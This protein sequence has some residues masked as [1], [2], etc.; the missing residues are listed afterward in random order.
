MRP[1]Y[2]ASLGDRRERRLRRFFSRSGGC[3]GGAPSKRSA[4]ARRPTTPA[5]TCSFRSANPGESTS[6]ARSPNSA[7]ARCAP[8]G[9]SPS[10]CRS[11]RAA[12][13]S[14]CSTTSPWTSSAS[15]VR[16]R[17]ASPSSRSL[18]SRSETAHQGTVTWRLINMLSMNH[19]GLVERGGGK[20]AA[21]LREMLS[22]FADLAD[23][24]TERKIRGIRSVDSR[25][26]VRRVRERTG[27]GAGARHRDHRHA[28]RE[29]VRGQR[30]VPA[31]RRAGALLRRIFGLNHFTQTVICTPERG[32]IMRWPPRM[33]T[34]RPL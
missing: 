3:R 25:P 11:A 15:P 27:I 2:S 1:L 22:M 7:C 24:A 34:R 20:N 33:G 4:T 28:R 29:G 5:P 16:R 12:P 14:A 21:A 8:I 9:T 18:R 31:R 6:R 19:L 32:E 26:V 30:R 17:R 23:S 13:I 10:I